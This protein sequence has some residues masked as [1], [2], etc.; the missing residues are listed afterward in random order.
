MEEE[1]YRQPFKRIISEKGKHSSN[2]SVNQL[3]THIE[4]HTEK[5]VDR[6]VELADHAN[7]KTIQEQDIESAIKQLTEED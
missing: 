6:A 3:K 7:R 2:E 5:I 1:L 4:N